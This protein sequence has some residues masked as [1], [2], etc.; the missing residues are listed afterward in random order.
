M[1]GGPRAGVWEQNLRLDS[2]PGSALKPITAHILL[3][4]VNGRN[5]ESTAITTHSCRAPEA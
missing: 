3:C 5:G 4:Y 1:W 2:D